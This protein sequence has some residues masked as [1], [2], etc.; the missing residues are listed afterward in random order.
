MK[1]LGSA[2]KVTQKTKNGENTLSL[3]NSWSIFSLV[4]FNLVDNQYQHKSEVLYT[5]K[6]KKPYAYLLNIKPI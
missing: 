3:W 5:F 6:P 4:Q 2:K 1:L